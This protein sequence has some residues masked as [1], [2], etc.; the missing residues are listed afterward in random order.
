MDSYR[1]LDVIKLTKD[2]FRLRT[3]WSKV[4]VRAG[5][6]FNVG[7]TGAGVNREYSIYS[8]VP[9]DHLEFLIRAVE[10][11]V[12]SPKLQSLRPGDYVDIDGPYGSFCLERPDDRSKK[13][14]FV[15]TGTGIA[16]FHSFA[17]SF[18]NLDY[19]ILHGVRYPEEQ[20]DKSDYEEGRYI[21]CIS[22]NPKGDSKRVTDYLRAHPVSADTTVYICGNR[23]M[24]V[25]AYEI[26]REQGVPGDNLFTEVFF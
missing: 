15:A 1:V 23:N 11:G 18:P 25:E 26:L 3:E 5:Q 16:P 21:P 8:P 17:K 7:P 9:S 2:T 22:R 6:C 12:V 24:I 20:Y 13:Y 14:L 10:G 19:R 4:P